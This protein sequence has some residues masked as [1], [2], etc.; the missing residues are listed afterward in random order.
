MPETFQ[1]TG[2]GN[3]HQSNHISPP[4][5]FVAASL[6]PIKETTEAF[7]FVSGVKVPAPR[8]TGGIVVAHLGIGAQ[9]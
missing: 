7:L 2:P 8:E 3:A 4:G 5:D 6:M 1:I 9:A